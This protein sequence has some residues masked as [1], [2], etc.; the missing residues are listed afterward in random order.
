MYCTLSYKWKNN[1]K[2]KSERIGGLLNYVNDDRWK[3]V[4]CEEELNDFLFVVVNQPL[5]RTFD[6]CVVL[7][8]KKPV[9]NLK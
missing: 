5:I 8:G 4:G 2:Y 6:I 3:Q 7:A 9:F 1:Y